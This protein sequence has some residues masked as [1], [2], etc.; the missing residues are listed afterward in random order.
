LQNSDVQQFLLE[1]NTFSDHSCPLLVEFCQSIFVVMNLLALF[2]TVVAANSTWFSSFQGCTRYT[3]IQEN[4]PPPPWVEGN[5]S[6]SRLAGKGKKK[7]VRNFIE[8]RRKRK[9]SRK[10]KVKE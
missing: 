5:I 8:K 2:L 9:D 6:N 4:T 3:N 7:K 10:L 1:G